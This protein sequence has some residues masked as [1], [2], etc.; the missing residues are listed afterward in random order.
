M[1]HAAF[2]QILVKSTV[3]DERL[4][5]FELKTQQRSAPQL[6]AFIVLLEALKLNLVTFDEEDEHLWFFPEL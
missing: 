3:T 5:E 1:G 4:A 6:F 2:T